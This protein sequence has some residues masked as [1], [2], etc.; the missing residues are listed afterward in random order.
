MGRH[1]ESVL[2]LI[3]L[4]RT[5]RPAVLD[6]SL[7]PPPS[8]PR[9]SSQD[10][11]PASEHAQPFLLQRIHIVERLARRR[12]SRDTCDTTVCWCGLHRTYGVIRWLSWSPWQLCIL[13]SY[14]LSTL[15]WS[16]T[17]SSAAC[18]FCSSSSPR[19][20]FIFSPCFHCRRRHLASSIPTAAVHYTHSCCRL[21]RQR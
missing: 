2:L 9:V 12:S 21:S 1:V 15:I 8:P 5:K 6:A 20:A 14:I 7:P 17:L 18:V 3:T 16:T 4:W 13:H 11:V 10:S 19:F